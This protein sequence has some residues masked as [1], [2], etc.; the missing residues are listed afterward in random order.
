VATLF[1]SDLHLHAERPDGIEQFLRFMR[2]DAAHASALYILG[3]L[4][5]GWIGDDDTDPSLAPIIAALAELKRTGVPCYFMHGN[6]D[7]LIGKRFAAATGCELLNEW[8]VIEIEGRRVLLTHGDLLCTDDTSYQALR[9]TVRDAAW[10]HDFLAKSLEERRAIVADLRERSKTETAAKPTD[11]MDVNRTAIEAALRAHDVNILLHG[12]THRPAVH[13][14]VV[15][16][17][18]AT[19]IVLGDWYQ[20]GSVLRWDANGFDLETL[21]RA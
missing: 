17:A 5:E 2:S 20:R 16:G 15:A 6:R 9:T 10:Q 1:I 8:H 19:R 7:F 4:F 12:H 14:L 3:D 18:P 21:E 11:I 13:E